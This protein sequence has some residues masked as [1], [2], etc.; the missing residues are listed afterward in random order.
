M[1]INKSKL[2]I[3]T[4]S[5]IGITMTTSGYALAD[6]SWAERIKINGDFRY[7]YELA[8]VLLNK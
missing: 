6:G 7:R 3:A 8:M 5:L 1:I 2:T 4:F